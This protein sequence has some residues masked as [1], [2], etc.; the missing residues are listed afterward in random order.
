MDRRRAEALQEARR[1]AALRFS[2]IAAKHT[3][4]NLQ[5]VY[6][7]KLTGCAW[8]RGRKIAVPRPITRRA[9]HVYLHEVGHV[10]LNH[11]HDKPVHVQEFEA[12]QWAF[13]IMQ[14]EGVAIHQKSIHRAK[15]YVAQKIMQAI[16]SGNE[17]V[18]L[19]A[20][21]FANVSL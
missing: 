15:A 2:V 5:I 3:P 19:D 11:V 17:P 7:K 9:L 18:H 13:A 8:V 12:E 20:A 4:P 16:M 6:R 1:K 14:R 21:R 10:V